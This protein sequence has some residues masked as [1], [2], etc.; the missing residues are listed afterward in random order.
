MMFCPPGQLE[1]SKSMG[2]FSMATRTPSSSAT[3]KMGF[4]TS[5][6]SARF[7]STVLSVMRPM[8]LVTLGTPSFAAARMTAMR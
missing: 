5:G 1:A 3:A 4:Q 2:Q 8:K 7:S 6:T